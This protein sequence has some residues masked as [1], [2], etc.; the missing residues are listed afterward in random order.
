MNFK[1]YFFCSLIFIPILLSA[2]EFNATKLDSFFM[3]LEE[4]DRFMGSVGLA[5][6][7][8]VFYQKTM[9][10]SDLSKNKKPEP[11]TAYRIGSISKTFTAT[12]IMQAVDESLIQLD[13]NIDKWFPEIP[14]GDRISIDHL[15]RHSSGLYN[16]TNDPNYLEWNTQAKTEAELIEIIISQPLQFESGSKHSYSNS[17]YVLLSFILEKIYDAT[18]AD[19]L[20]EKIISPLNLKHT[21]IEIPENGMNTCVKS[22]TKLSSWVESTETHLS[23]PLGAGSIASTVED[24]SIFANALFSNQLTSEKSLNLMKVIEGEFGIGIF[25]LPFHTH[26]AF[27]H[28]GG[29]DGFLSIFGHFPKDHITCVVLSNGNAFDNNHIA[30]AMLSAW[31]GL[32]FDIPEFSHYE[33]YEGTLHSYVGEYISS[34]I[35]LSLSITVRDN[36]LFCQAT[37]QPAF[38]LEA[39]EEDLFEFK[40]AEIKITFYPGENAMKLKQSGMEF[41]FTRKD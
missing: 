37:G 20:T 12:M 4:N 24:L 7:G 5:K 15:L 22:Y 40:M 19:I 39:I 14:S 8:Q 27:G 1:H 35:P 28:T 9:G 6:D 34:Q 13:E 25:K 32:P 30:I 23:I 29:I 10:Y 41:S 38:P 21:F 16:F 31:Y 26:T 17:N 36:T 11:H 2:Q 18:F 33:V 3:A